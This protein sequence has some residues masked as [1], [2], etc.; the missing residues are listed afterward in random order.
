VY[1]EAEWQCNRKSSYHLDILNKV[2][3]DITHD[4]AIIIFVPRFVVRARRSVSGGG[5]G[6][7]TSIEAAL[8]TDRVVGVRRGSTSA[9]SA[10]LSWD[11]E[12]HVAQAG[13]VFGVRL[14]RVYY[15]WAKLGDKPLVLGPEEADIGDLE[16]DHTETLETE[17]ECPAR[18]VGHAWL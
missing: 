6:L 13:R 14:K 12:G 11:P 15:A 10:N 8:R 2:S 16:E 4:L 3:S 5:G 7:L 9:G 1:L 18:F 17:A